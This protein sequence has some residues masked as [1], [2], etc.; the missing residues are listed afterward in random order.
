MSAE[1][2]L[3]HPRFAEAR[4]A[5][6]D[7]FADVFT[8]DAFQLRL[9][10]DTGCLVLAA[11]LV[12]L[13]AAHDE[14]DRATWA[15][16]SRLQGLVAGHGLSSPR[17]LA[18]LIARFRATGYLRSEASA[19]DRRVRLLKPTEAL[20][21]KDRTRTAVMH[22][23]LH[24]LYPDRRYAAVV[25]EDPIAHL[26]LRKTGFL[27]MPTAIGYMHRHPAIMA[28]MARDAGYVALLLVIQ[29]M[30]SGPERAS[31]SL[32]Y[33][34]IAGRLRVSRTHIRNLFADAEAAG[35]VRLSKTGGN[36]A[37]LR[38]RF[39]RA[40]DRFLADQESCRDA[41]GQ[42]ALA[43]AGD[44]ITAPAHW[45]NAHRPSA[46]ARARRQPGAGAG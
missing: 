46:P 20:I 44:G 16:L 11:L 5:H 15:T 12:A 28:F 26:V 9:L 45:A 35:H 42:A 38:P 7:G 37:E 10:V 22:R 31:E 3:A 6:I 17:H 30:L 40:F 36:I 18:D 25:S 39:L 14:N 43:R 32:N 34:S 33:K 13:H 8:R 27:M 24:I 23:A 21:A 41:V 4:R 2:I 1:E 29:A 19:T